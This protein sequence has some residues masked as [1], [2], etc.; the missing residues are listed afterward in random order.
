MTVAQE[1]G[2]LLGPEAVLEGTDGR[3]R[4]YLSDA[5]E[6]R[7]IHG[8]ADAVALPASA[9]DA[10][11]VLRWCYE[12]DVPLIPRGGGTGFA[13]G[14]VPVDGGVVLGTERLVG[15]I[16]IDPGQW[17]AQVPAGTV[18][19]QVHRRARETGL[20]FGPDPG[21]SEQSLLGGNVATNAGG[22][23]TFKYGVTGHWVTGLEV[24]VAPGELIKLGGPVRKDVAGYDL[25]SL[26]IGSEGTL[27]VVT[28]VWLRLIPAPE[29]AL[30]VAGLYPDLGSGCR[31]VA[32]VLG[33]GLIPATLEFLD[34][35]TLRA[36]LGALIGAVPDLAGEADRAR[37][38]VIAEADGREDE[39]Q[40][41]RGELIQAMEEGAVSVH[42]PTARHDVD[43][44]WRWRGGVSM[45]VAAQRGGKL[46]EDIAV[47]VDQLEAAL[48]AVQEIGQ[49]HGL[50]T[51]SWGHAG[52]GNLHAT[53]LLDRDERAEV[54]RAEVASQELFD[55]A[56][57]LGGSVSGEHGIGLVKR[58]A[59][60]RQWDPAAVRLHEQVKRVFDPKGLLNPGKKLARY[61]AVSEP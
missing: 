55:L 8:R 59:L 38:L 3:A 49:R 15:P 52:D 25:R 28:S 35:A 16:R 7:A 51:C 47:P 14:A 41:L 27:G 46:S 57:R 54:E 43:G 22:P 10:A 9:S 1:L 37:F 60:E 34:E 18:T 31:A 42:A 61:G 50:P 44:L 23:H 17:R 56:I 58:G 20:F 21:A 12:H 36:S 29:A 30:P 39:A 53:F 48:R 45:A 11:G 2:G 13:G 40:G 6:W 19:A 33:S 5:T 4:A 32:N 26:L 24:A